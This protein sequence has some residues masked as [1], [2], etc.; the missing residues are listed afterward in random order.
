MKSTAALIRL[1][2]LFA[3]FLALAG[4]LIVFGVF[5][6]CSR[7]ASEAAIADEIRN[8][9]PA[10]NLTAS[11]LVQA[12]KAD[13]ESAAAAYNGEVGIV[14]GPTAVYDESGHY[15]RI[16]ASPVWDVRC[17]ASDEEI[18][19]VNVLRHSGFRPSGG[20]AKMYSY[21][22]SFGTRPIFAFKGRVQGI[23][24]KLLT[25]DMRGC[26]VHE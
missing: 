11:E 26:I 23:N 24:E 4:L 8:L 1:L 13:E 7:T 5:R 12:Y 25:I 19:K 22:G 21:G 10:F 9:P 18:D 20:V 14:E 16:Y 6:G 2:S 17:F 15:L 3:V